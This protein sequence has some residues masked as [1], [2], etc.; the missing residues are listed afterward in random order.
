V[1]HRSR[2]VEICVSGWGDRKIFRVHAGA[3]WH[4]EISQS[5]EAIHFM[6]GDLLLP[7][8]LQCHGLPITLKQN[9][10]VGIKGVCG[11][12]LLIVLDTWIVGSG[13]RARNAHDHHCN[14]V[15]G[16]GNL[17]SLNQSERIG[18][19][20]HVFLL[21]ENEKSLQL[22]YCKGGMPTQHCM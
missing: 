16:T 3:F 17:L 11:H 6:A 18:S 2:A 12:V 14:H 20:R 4:Y 9:L 22:W 8:D 13:G 5:L 15:P 19:L 1:W 10:V 21:V 7:H